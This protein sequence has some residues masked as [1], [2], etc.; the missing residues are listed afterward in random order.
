MD[1]NT[2]E[3]V[4]IKRIIFN[5]GA[6]DFIISVDQYVAVGKWKGFIKDNCISI[7]DVLRVEN[8]AMSYDDFHSL[9]AWEG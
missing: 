2:K 6:P 9:E 8:G 1:K 5:N 7:A 3:K 4:A